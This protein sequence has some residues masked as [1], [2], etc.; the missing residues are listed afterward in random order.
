[1]SLYQRGKSWYYDFVHKGQRYTGTFGNVSRTTAKE[2]LARKKTEVLEQKL[3]PAKARKSPR[4]DAFAEEYLE[5]G[6][7][8]KKPLTVLRN[9]KAAN[10]LVPFFGTKKLNEITSW[11]IEQYKK[12]R[13][14]AGLAPLTINYE[15]SLLK[16]L[17][18]KAREWG[19][20]GET[21]EAGVKKLT[22]PQSRTRFVSEE[23]EAR[24]L[25]V[26]TP[27][28]HRVVL[29][30]LL[31][32]FRRQELAALRLEDVD[33]KR[34]TVKV[35]ATFAKNG[36]SRTLPIGPRLRT[37]IESALAVRGDLHVV[38]TTEQ[39]KP[40][41]PDSLSA[42]IKYA[43]RKAGLGRFGPHVLRH[44][45]AS[46]LVMAGIDIRTVQELMGHKSIGM[47]MRYAHIS[48]DHSRAAME[49]LEQRFSAKSPANFHNTPQNT[50][51][52][53]EQKV[54][55]LR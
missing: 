29:I 28:L 48:P 19:K 26:C 11:H 20:L 33:L 14:E 9:R 36:E 41:T 39:G 2:E 34:G 15:L 23:E 31:T 25:A 3:N 53:M 22:A 5:W 8:N 42:A 43:G 12:G 7:A 49:T 6:K 10:V 50:T 21:P 35:A 18:R 30:A 16:S 45:F 17:L 47:T 38:L 32:G 52:P 51:P 1:M 27:A 46:R 4:F 55:A 13:K 54:V 44:T 24:L 37:V 40:W